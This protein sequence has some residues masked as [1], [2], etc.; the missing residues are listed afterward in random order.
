MSFPFARLAA[1]AIVAGCASLIGCGG[2][3]SAQPSAA[4]IAPVRSAATGATTSGATSGVSSGLAPVSSATLE[5]V[6]SD[7]ADGAALVPSDQVVR[8]S[9]A[10]PVDDQTLAGISAAIRGVP[11]AI[12]AVSSGAEVELRPQPA[13]PGGDPVVLRIT[14][15]LRSL[16]GLK[17]RPRAIGFTCHAGP[18]PAQALALPG[19]ARAASAVVQLG[20][21]P[22]LITGGEVAALSSAVDLYDPA[23]GELS[24][25]APLAEARAGH[26]ATRLADGRVLVAGGR[27]AERKH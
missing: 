7:P 11:I 15:D 12:S 13:W 21:G 4:L 18:A 5:L 10:E 16:S 1:G 26:S 25:A 19:G 23:T 17:A 9:F 24:A 6:L 3:S 2:H 27:G 22:L 14:P 8:L 20:E